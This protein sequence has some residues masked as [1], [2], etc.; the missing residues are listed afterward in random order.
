[1]GQDILETMVETDEVVTTKETKSSIDMAIQSHKKVVISNH[2]WEDK[3]V[4]DPGSDEET[5]V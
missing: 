3:K 1:M 4:E 2:K 5:K